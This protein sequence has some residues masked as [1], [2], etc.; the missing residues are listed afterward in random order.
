MKRTILVIPCY[1]EAQRLPAKEFKNF[2]EKEGNISFIFVNDGS[3]DDTFKVLEKL[4]S[5]S[6]NMSILDIAKNSGKAE[7]VRQGVIEALKDRPDYVGFWDAD[8][9]TPLHE[10]NNFINLLNEKDIEMVSGLRLARLGANVKRRLLRHYL[11]RVFATVVSALLGVEVYDTQCGAKIFHN[12]LAEKIFQEPFCTRW[13]FDVELFKRIIALKGKTESSKK[14]YEYPL[15][16]WKEVGV[17]KI[18]FWDCLKVPFEI[19][20]IFLK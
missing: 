18:S 10:I 5:H 16:C 2:A 17:S 11:G 14:L 7:A 19:I 6:K 4:T 20:K 8:L 12:S 3:S 15:G 13:L 9:A 1:N